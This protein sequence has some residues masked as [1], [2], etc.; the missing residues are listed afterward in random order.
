M[1]ESKDS[2]AIE[3]LTF[4]WNHRQESI[5]HSWLK[6]NHSLYDA[7]SLAVRSG[8]QFNLGDISVIFNRFRG[9]YWMGSD[10]EW[11]YKLAVIY[12]HSS[13]YQAYEKYASRK[14]FI[15]KGA[16]IHTSTGD[17]PA[18]QG[19]SRLIVGAEFQYNG[20]RVQVTSFKD[21]DQTVIACSYADDGEFSQTTC[22]KCGETKTHWPKKKL[23]R[24]Y[25][26]THADLKAGNK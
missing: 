24:R 14:P 10:T 25:A 4:V 17:G 23:A 6:M 15:V 7:L 1:T 16:S 22:K 13:A 21:T 12:R 5:S 18:G 8:M 19:L 2:T 3:F 11:F 9:G 26:L 20:E